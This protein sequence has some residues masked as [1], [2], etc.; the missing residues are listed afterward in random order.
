MVQ[1]ETT[2][3]H[4]DAFWTK[5][6]DIADIYP[7]SDTLVQN[8]FR[9]TAVANKR[10][11]EVG[12]GSGRDSAGIAAAGGKVTVVDYADQALKTTREVLRRQN[13]PGNLIR[14]DGFHLPF[15]DNSFDIVFHQ[16]VLE[17]FEDPLPFFRENVRV[18]RPGG[19]LLIDVPQRWHIYTVIKKILIAL[20]AW[21][22]GWETEFSIRDLTGLYEAEGL[23]V[24]HRYGDWMYPSL[25]Y[26]SFRE[27]LKKLGLRLP[28]Y[29]PTVPGLHT[30]RRRFRHWFGGTP[31][32][33]YSFLTI[34]VVGRKG[35]A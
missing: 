12:G 26:R 28:L 2:Q 16:G 35:P 18:L 3:A 5:E 21:F 1:K 17:H 25:C 11:L 8:L 13:L 9:L 22:A 32:A 19:L 29:P 27:V 34:G 31:L 23:E 7:H 20:N 15:P 4:W 6:Q 14:A 33:L 10:V 30:L 24:I